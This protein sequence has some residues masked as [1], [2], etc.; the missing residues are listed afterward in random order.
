[1]A[2][3]TVVANVTAG[4]PVQLSPT[5]VRVTGTAFKADGTPMVE[6]FEQRLVNPERFASGRRT[7]RAPGEGSLT[8]DGTGGYTATYA[9]LTAADVSK[10]LRAE[11]RALWLGPDGLGSEMT[12]FEAEDPAGGIVNGPQAPCVAPAEIG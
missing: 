1:V 10:A 11:S 6:L 3:E 7:L 9:N 2:E 4:K 8:F 5:S 12:I